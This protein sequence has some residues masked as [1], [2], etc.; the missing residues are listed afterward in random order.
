MEETGLGAGQGAAGAPV[1]PEGAVEEGRGLRAAC[2]ELGPGVWE[3]T[4]GTVITCG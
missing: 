3:L 2:G 4:D 1:E